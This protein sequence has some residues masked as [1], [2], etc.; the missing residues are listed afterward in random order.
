MLDKKYLL[1]LWK[2]NSSSDLYT[3]TSNSLYENGQDFL[4]IQWYVVWA[5]GQLQLRNPDDNDDNH[6]ARNSLLLIQVDLPGTQ[7]WVGV[8]IQLL[9]GGP[10][11]AGSGPV[12]HILGGPRF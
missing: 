9:E 11:G 4:D 6:C 3:C 8:D 12:N 2:E 1:L 7:Q 10:G 5:P